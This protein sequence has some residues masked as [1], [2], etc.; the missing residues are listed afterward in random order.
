V[1]F[2]AT[3]QRSPP[4]GKGNGTIIARLAWRCDPLRESEKAFSRL[5]SFAAGP[6]RNGVRFM[7]KGTIKYASTGGWGFTQFDDD[8]PAGEAAHNTCL[9]CHAAVT[10]RDF[11]FNR[12]A[13]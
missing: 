7:V 5:Q 8:K 11:V 13:P 12:Y 9:P 10:A 6:P 2:W 4:P 3:T 1:P